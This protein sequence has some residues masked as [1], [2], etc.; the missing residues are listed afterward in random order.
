MGLDWSSLIPVTGL[1]GPVVESFPSILTHS[2]PSFNR[3]RH[4]RH[5]PGERLGRAQH[6][7]GKRQ[8]LCPSRRPGLPD[9]GD[10]TCSWVSDV[11]T[12]NAMGLDCNA[13]IQI[14]DLSEVPCSVGTP[15]PHV[16]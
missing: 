3:G 12:G 8:R 16:R 6:H 11:A 4:R 9:N 5:E 10:D 7:T 13:L 1:D 15:F 14:D 2:N